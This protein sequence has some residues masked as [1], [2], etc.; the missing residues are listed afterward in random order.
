MIRRA[1]SPAE[2]SSGT[3]VPSAATGFGSTR[4]RTSPPVEI[5]DR[6]E[7]AVAT[8]PVGER[9]GGAPACALIGA[10]SA[11]REASATRMSRSTRAPGFES[12]S[13][14]ANEKMS[15]RVGRRSERQEAAGDGQR[16][17]VVEGVGD[18]SCCRSGPESGRGA[19]R[20]R[21][22]AQAHVVGVVDDADG[23][24]R[25]RVLD[26]EP[27]VLPP[28]DLD[29][30]DRSL[31]SLAQ[32]ERGGRSADE[33]EGVPRRLVLAVLRPPERVPQVERRQPRP[34]DP[35]G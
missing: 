17:G 18:R 15:K 31:P 30:V 6:V 2:P 1:S 29:L 27:P 35:T 10:T 21:L 13:G 7:Q 5:G 34:P 4:Q 22:H 25:L 12:A 8:D 33:V 3:S 32:G 24:D 20:L 23:R 16:H 11:S 14:A 9:A 26:P 19:R 28:V